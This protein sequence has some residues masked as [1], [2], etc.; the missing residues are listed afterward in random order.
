MSFDKHRVLRAAAIWSIAALLSAAP[1]W[2]TRADDAAGPAASAPQP[3]PEKP[4][5]PAGGSFPAQPPPVENRGFLNGVGNW[6]DQSVSDFTAKMRAARDK[7]KDLNKKEN[8]V[9][10]DAATATGEALKDAAQATKDAATAV[11]RLPNTRVLELNDR[12]AVAANGAPDC[13][14]ASTNACRQK[15]FNSGQPIDVRTQQEC[16]P[17]VL[18][19]GRTPAEGECPDATFV[20]RAVCQ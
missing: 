11:V 19:S 15:G 14:V 9:A 18:L 4:T 5:A 2:T 6:W 3:V 13:G 8:N 12:C 1:V 10:K 7:L 16:P 20:L 17:A